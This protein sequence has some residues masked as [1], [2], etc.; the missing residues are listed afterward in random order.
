MNIIITGAGKG[1]GLE[2]CKRFLQYPDIHILAISRDT[3]K[4]EIIARE[5]SFLH[6]CSLDLENGNYATVINQLSSLP[7]GKAAVLINNAG[8]LLKKA[9]KDLN[10]E[11]NKR[12]LAVNYLAPFELIQMLLPYFTPDAH[13]V[14]ISSM[15]GFQGSIKF[16]QLSGYSASKAALACLTECLAVELQERNIKVNCLCPGSVQTEMFQ[17]AFPGSKASAEPEKI[18]GFIVEFALNAHHFMN[19]KIIP[20]SLSVP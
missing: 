14:N 7:G 11:D 16:D 6:P 2:L 18:A 4:L 15:G 1:I 8:L 13:I 20:L 12:M 10:T 19:G 9:F 3:G 5:H 17:Q